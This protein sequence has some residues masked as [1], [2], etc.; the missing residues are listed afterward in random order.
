MVGGVRAIETMLANP[1]DVDK[2]DHDLHRI[3]D[4]YT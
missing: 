3:V 4:N 1:V 2:R